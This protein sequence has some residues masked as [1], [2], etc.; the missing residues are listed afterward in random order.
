MNF[1]P[2]SVEFL[3][4]DGHYKINRGTCTEAGVAI[5]HFFGAPGSDDAKRQEFYT[6]LNEK[7]DPIPS[8]LPSFPLWKQFNPQRNTFH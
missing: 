7:E 5:Y 1:S 3:Y 2:R 8:C 4:E 6:R